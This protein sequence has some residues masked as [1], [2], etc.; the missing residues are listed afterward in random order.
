MIATF[1]NTSCME[2]HRYISNESVDL[3]FCDPP[4]FITSG[5]KSENIDTGNRVDWDNQWSCKDDFLEWT[6]AWMRLMY[7][8]LKNDG[9]AYICVCWEHSGDFKR[10]LE[11]VGFK[12]LNRIT[13]KRDKGRG[14]CRNWKSM[15]ED[16]WFVSKTNSYKFNVD[17]VMVKKKVVA[18]YRD[19][20]G[21]PK[22]WYEDSDGK[23][24]YTYP[25]NVWVDFTVPFW[26]M[27]EVRSYATTKRS[28]ENTLKKHSTQKPKAMVK[29]CIQA[30]SNVGDV[31]VDYFSGSGT[32]AIAAMELDRKV[33]AFDISSV[34]SEMLETRI[35]NELIGG[36]FINEQIC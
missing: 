5:K 29:Y 7:A 25:G 23:Y 34:C 11:L 20:D 14:S 6:E 4:Y 26:S 17:E 18:P 33:I 31:V 21:N 19:E 35:R 8:Q 28:M 27:K 10:I 30:S 3:F 9:S 22:D 15:S 16:I 36:E 1:Y 2:S 24:R 12:I 13:W 32:T